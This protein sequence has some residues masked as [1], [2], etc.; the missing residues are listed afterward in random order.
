MHHNYWGKR[1]ILKSFDLSHRKLWLLSCCRHYFRCFSQKSLIKI[2]I[3]KHLRSRRLQKSQS[4]LL[5]CWSFTLQASASHQSGG[6][7]FTYGYEICK[8]CTR[9]WYKTRITALY[10]CYTRSQHKGTPARLTQRNQQHS[11]FNNAYSL[12][13]ILRMLSSTPELNMFI[14]SKTDTFYTGILYWATAEWPFLS[15]HGQNS[16]R[17]NSRRIL[18]RAKWVKL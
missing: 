5:L 18:M 15:Q 8:C 1:I 16:S 14:I 17:Y 4:S 11:T 2:K 9:F 7:N 3:D 12:M 10:F 6:L 13:H